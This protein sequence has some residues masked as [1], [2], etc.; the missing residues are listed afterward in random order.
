MANCLPALEDLSAVSQQDKTRGIC[1]RL[2][3]FTKKNARITYERTVMS[4]ATSTRTAATVEALPPSAPAPAVDPG[5]KGFPK[6]PR[7]S[8]CMARFASTLQS[9]QP[10]D[11]G[12]P[13]AGGYEPTQMTEQVERGGSTAAVRP[14][15]VQRRPGPEAWA[16][17]EA[18]LCRLTRS[19]P[20]GYATRS[21]QQSHDQNKCIHTCMRPPP[22]F[23][24]SNACPTAV[25]GHPVLVRPASAAAPVDA[26]PAVQA[27]A[28]LRVFA[29]TGAVRPM[30]TARRVAAA[31]STPGGS[32]EPAPIRPTRP[33]S[34]SA[35]L[36]EKMGS[37]VCG[38]WIIGGRGGSS[39]FWISD[40][41]ACAGQVDADRS[42]L[43]CAGKLW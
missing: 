38:R 10:V 1:P 25:A 9:A 28:S 34:R 11:A 19:L 7:N 23:H 39:G 5:E 22:S 3:L 35:L 29:A 42:E 36:D 4:P 37:T 33:D 27:A 15:A 40:W 43:C 6:L 21:K 20:R 18:V 41:D 2:P 12:A 24:S 16:G 14:K 8:S 13:W 31:D 26:A 32:I 30:R 17:E